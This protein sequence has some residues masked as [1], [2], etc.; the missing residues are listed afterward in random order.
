[1]AKQSVV[2]RLL[3]TSKYLHCLNN[4]CSYINIIISWNLYLHYVQLHR[5]LEFRKLRR[6]SRPFAGVLRKDPSPLFKYAK[7]KSKGTKTNK[8]RMAL[9]QAFVN[10][11][12]FNSLFSEK[13]VK[14]S[15]IV[16]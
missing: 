16:V 8:N 10:S 7:R 15:P 3:K 11:S 1:M 5:L 13:Q 2:F 12:S 9:R 14:F 6:I 4:S